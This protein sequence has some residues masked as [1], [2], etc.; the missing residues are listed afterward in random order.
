MKFSI[1][2]EFIKNR[3]LRARQIKDFVPKIIKS[4]SNMYIYQKEDG[5]VF[6]QN[7]N[8]PLFKKL[9]DT[10]NSGYKR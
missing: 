2:E 4:S 6:S 3:V 7:S 5:V 10:S 8:L 9:L 1:D